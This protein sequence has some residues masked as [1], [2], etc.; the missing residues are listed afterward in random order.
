MPRKLRHNPYVEGLTYD[1]L[2]DSRDIVHHHEHKEIAS[3]HQTQIEEAHYDEGTD[4]S[5]STITGEPESNIEEAP[6]AYS[7]DASA[8]EDIQDD[9]CAYVHGSGSVTASDSA[10]TAEK[11]QDDNDDYDY[12]E[13]AD[14]DVMPDDS[15]A[16]S[17]NDDETTQYID[18]AL[19]RSSEHDS[20]D[21]NEDEEANVERNEY[22]ED[23]KVEV[24]N[25]KDELD[26][27]LL[28]HEQRLRSRKKQKCELRLLE[29]T[30][31]RIE[32]SGAEVDL[33]ILH[34]LLKQISTA[35]QLDIKSRYPGEAGELYM[36]IFEAIRTM[37]LI[38]SRP[39]I[40]DFESECDRVED[41]LERARSPED[42]EPVE[43]QSQLPHEQSR[44]EAD[45]W[46]VQTT[47]HEI[48]LIHDEQL[49]VLVTLMNMKDHSKQKSS[50]KTSN[51][52]L[53]LAYSILLEDLALF[54]YHAT[55]GPASPSQEAAAMNFKGDA[56]L[57]QVIRRRFDAKHRWCYS[58]DFKRLAARHL[59]MEACGIR[60]WFE[61]SMKE[62]WKLHNIQRTLAKEAV[63]Q[64]ECL[65]S[66][67]LNSTDVAMEE[68]SET[69]YEVSRMFKDGPEAISGDGV[70]YQ[71]RTGEVVKPSRAMPTQ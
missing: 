37:H 3:A 53:Q 10:D 36:K 50:H 65:L 2:E 18:L 30:R 8:S 9:F 32:T 45:G 19:D 6:D 67:T 39:R 64:Y 12:S 26:T 20:E 24:A 46:R 4:L 47:S 58:Q 33:F 43:K 42:K 35:R 27:L 66:L 13:S 17:N 52:G 55:L 28:A 44:K 11:T 49:P 56:L 60:Q 62:L 5:F 59:I 63:Y 57:V 38:I 34:V 61:E 22:I 68:G 54:P 16:V 71:S 69:D 48:A 25:L 7:G 1:S 14:N 21:E 23:R 15:N 51:K 40:R 41:G 70:E 31:K 29:T